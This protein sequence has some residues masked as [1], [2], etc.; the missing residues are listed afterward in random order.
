MEDSKNRV[1]WSSQ[2]EGREFKSPL[3]LQSHFVLE[4]Q[5]QKIPRYAENYTNVTPTSSYRPLNQ[6][7]GRRIKNL[8]KIIIIGLVALIGFVPLLWLIWNRWI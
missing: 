4:R 8:L 5:G 6:G 3:P 1:D 2:A 7:E